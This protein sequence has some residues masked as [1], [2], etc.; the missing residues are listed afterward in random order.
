MVWFKAISTGRGQSM[1]GHTVTYKTTKGKET[2]DEF[3]PRKQCS[4]ICIL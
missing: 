3:Q 1:Q 2:V 4:Q